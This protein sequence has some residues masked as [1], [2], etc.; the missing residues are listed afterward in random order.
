M[1]YAP[2]YSQV[3]EEID[4]VALSLSNYVIENEVKNITKS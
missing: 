1:S 3:K 4:S 2:T